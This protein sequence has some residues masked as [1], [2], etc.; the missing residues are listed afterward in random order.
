MQ[1]RAATREVSSAETGVR[2]VLLE[3]LR[4]QA[5]LLLQ[6]CQLWAV[7]AILATS[8]GASQHGQTETAGMTRETASE[9]NESGSTYTDL[10]EV[11]Y[12]QTLQMSL[13]NLKGAFNLQCK[14]DGAMVRFAFAFLAPTFPLFVLICCLMLEMI[15][16]GMGISAA[17][18]A[19]VLL[20]IGGAS[21]TSDLL[22]CQRVDGA[23][24]SL[25]E[26]F[27]FRRSLPYIFCHEESELNTFVDVMGYSTAFCYGALI[28]FCLLYLYGRQHV[29]MRSSRTSVATCTG[30]GNLKVCLSEVWEN[31]QS[32][33]K[34]LAISERRLVAATAAYVSV[35]LKGKVGV[36]LVDG[37]AMVTPVE[38]QSSQPSTEL[39]DVLSFLEGAGK[40]QQVTKLRCRTIADTL[41]ERCVLEEVATEDRVLFGAKNLLLKYTLCGNL[42]MEILQKLVAV[43]L[44]SVVTSVDC[45]HLSM[46]I[47]M[48]MAATCALVQPYL[49]PQVN[50][51]QCCC[52]LSLAMAAF[53]FHCRAA[54]FSRLAL[55]LPF[56]LSA[57]LCTLTPDSA[58]SL[59]MR[60]WKELDRQ[61]PALQSG[62]VVEVLPVTYSFI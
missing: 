21:S 26:G 48:A 61:L 39:E 10:W 44:V 42:W 24:D 36:Q 30:Q 43:A 1:L 12:V 31:E 57:A 8:P 51:L 23:G 11:P 38:G 25:P 18:Q 46:A 41:M 29:V 33:E 60:L 62:E 3:Q 52:F 53:S 37:V 4:A 59:A 7:L 34:D 28:P 14:F 35:L 45:L 13:T 15:C 6:M 55:V 17:L 47:T 32:S 50:T 58:E 20:Y 19:L 5:P 56:L 22:R 27:A 9:T 16:R 49:Q 2:Q 54:W 40:K